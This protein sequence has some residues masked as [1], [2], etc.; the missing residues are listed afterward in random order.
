MERLR[1]I[2]LISFAVLL[3]NVQG[4]SAALINANSCSQ[5]DVQ[6]AI[7]LASDGDTVKVPAGSCTWTPPGSWIA[8]VTIPDSKK[9]VLQGEGMDSSII[10]WNHESRALDIGA[11]GSRITGFGFL[12]GQDENTNG[13]SVSGEGWRVDNC[14]FENNAAS[15]VEGVVASAQ[16]DEGH[17]VGVVDNCIFKDSRV[18]MHGHA[19]LL[20]HEVWAEPL[21][22]GTDNAVFIE[23]CEFSRTMHGNAVDTNYGGRYV[24]RYNNLIDTY[25]EAHSVQGNHRTSRSWEIYGNTINQVGR[26]VWVPMLVRGGTGVVF[27]NN[28]TGTWGNPNIALDN[29]RSFE[30]VDVSGRCDGSS[31]WDGNEEPNGYPCRDQIG[32]STDEWLWTDLNPYPPQELDPAYF[33]NNKRGT[34]DVVPFI[35]NNCGDWIQEGRDYHTGMEKPGYLPYTYP[36]PSTM[37]VCGD[38]I[39]EG[40]EECDDGNT[41]DG[42]G[43]DSSCQI[44]GTSN[45]HYVRAGATGNNN[46]RDWNNAWNELPETLERGHTYYIADGNYPGYTFDDSEQG[47]E[48]IYIKKATADDH[49]TDDGWQDSYGDGI[50]TW[51]PISFKGSYYVFDGVTGGGHGNWDSGHGFEIY[52]SDPCANEGFAASIW[53]GTSSGYETSHLRIRHVKTYAPFPPQPGCGKA[54]YISPASPEKDDIQFS[55]CYF[56]DSGDVIITMYNSISNIV[57]EHS[58][59][60]RDASGT[61]PWAGNSH[62][63]CVEMGDVHGADVRYNQF[64]DI[65]GSGV[66][67]AYRTAEDIR[68]Y[69]N[70][71]FNLNNFNGNVGNGVIYTVSNAEGTIRNWQIHQNSFYYQNDY[72]PAILVGVCE[73]HN[74]CD[75][76]E[77]QAFNNMFLT[78]RVVIFDDVEHDYNAANY[79]VSE[80]NFQSISTDPYID[81]NSYDYRLSNPTNPGVVLPSPYN[82]DPDGNIRGVDGVWDRG[83]YEF[84]GESTCGNDICDSGETCSSCD[85][86]TQV[87]DADDNPCDNIVSLS[88]LIAYIDLWKAGEV[89]LQDVM[90]A[91]VAWKG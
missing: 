72:N 6:A 39:V 86:C 32:R 35:H 1:T 33:W 29:R 56:L 9:I 23:D 43:C 73:N 48:Y 70:Q 40:D 55:H 65:V 22:L 53:I 60:E 80:N 41:A 62:G 52:L 88:E 36:H 37:P 14:R 45:F 7:D 82:I 91:I 18:I 58:R 16:G 54:V 27:S 89:S 10:T 31:S 4:V 85:D 44:E 46:G 13:I 87:H 49:G 15:T 74:N 68:I 11:S 67:G 79:A 47:D 30:S 20:A 21:G 63:S 28:L 84:T 38:Y 5:Q 78:D 3:F 76:S 12:F 19:K 50:A 26:S 69:G 42:D 66:I 17:P 24:F 57:I 25:I 75:S 8:P 64:L 61:T 81:S 83:A 2:V 77:H 71:F 59:L 90:G 34:N 51:E